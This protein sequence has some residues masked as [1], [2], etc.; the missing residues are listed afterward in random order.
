MFDNYG[1][2]LL[3]NYHAYLISYSPSNLLIFI[4]CLPPIKLPHIYLLLSLHLS[5]PLTYTYRACI[6][7]ISPHIPTQPTSHL[8]PLHIPTQ[9]ASHL[10][11]PHIPT[12]P[13]SHLFPPHIPTQPTSHLFPTYT[14]TACISFIPLY[15]P[16]QPTSHLSPHIYL[17][18]LRLIYPPNIYLHSP[19]HIYPPTYT[20]TACISF[21]SPTYT[22]TA[23]ITSIPLYIPT[24]PTSH[25][26]P[27]IYLHSLHHI[28]PPTYTYTACISF[29]SPTYTYTA[30][31]TSIPLY[32]PTQPTSHLSPYIYLHSLRLIY[33]PPP[34][35]YL[36]CMYL[37]YLP[38]STA[39]S[40]S[41]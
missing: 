21:I 35:I 3:K 10:F 25:L 14:Y 13:T 34:Y 31:I 5:Y 37:I 19:H 9:P 6:S 1:Q 7:F 32:I 16:T 4:Y 12:Q 30:C 40:S 20:Y 28:Y 15:K 18:S 36:H 23:C 17:Q 29:I 24:Q 8:S 22:Y 38:D 11:P 2:G 26:S 27:K 33:P 41:G 39:K